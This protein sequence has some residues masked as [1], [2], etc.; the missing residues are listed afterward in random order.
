[1]CF[2]DRDLSHDQL[3]RRLGRLDRDDLPVLRPVRRVLHLFRLRVRFRD[4]R[5]DRDRGPAC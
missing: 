2:R 1:M 5:L 3:G 4:L